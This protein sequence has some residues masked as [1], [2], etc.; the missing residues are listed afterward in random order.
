MGIFNFF[1]RKKNIEDDINLEEALNI[2]EIKD[3]NTITDTIHTTNTTNDET[4]SFNYNFV[5]DNRNS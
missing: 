4:D 3:D 5:I 1:K 2:K